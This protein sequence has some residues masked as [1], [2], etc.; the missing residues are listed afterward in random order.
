MPLIFTLASRNLFHD[1]VR[2]IATVVGIVFSIVL[3]AVQLGL[4]LGFERMITIMID[5]SQADLWIAPAQ[6]KSFEST[7]MLD[8]R[9]RFQALAVEGVTAAVPV[10]IGFAYWRKSDGSAA[11][12]FLI[13]VEPGGLQPWDLAE[14]SLEDLSAPGAVAVDRSYFERLGVTRIGDMAEIRDQKARV[15][16]VTRGVRSFTTTPYVFTTIDRA[17]DYMGA[18]PNKATYFIVRTAPGARSPV[19]RSRIMM[20]HFSA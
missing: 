20:T 2:F 14:G 12:V 4:F 10:M 3:V 19:S 1:R 13:G 16:V 17:R 7:S 5:H 8:G 11:P 9:E 18:P 6:T 15:A